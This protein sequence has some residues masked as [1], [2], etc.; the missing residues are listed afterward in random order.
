MKNNQSNVQQGK[1]TK[2][3]TKQN[4]MNKETKNTASASS[5]KTSTANNS[6]QADKTKRN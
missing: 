2:A 4:P 3:D 6:K 1:D 5:K